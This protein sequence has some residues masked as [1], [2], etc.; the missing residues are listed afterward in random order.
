MSPDPILEVVIFEIK[1]GESAG[2]EAAIAQAFAFLQQTEGYLNHQ[3][4]R[5]L[6]RDHQ[7]LLTISWTT[8]DAHM[9]NFR[10]SDRFPRWRELIEPYFANPP[11]ML[12][13]QPI[14]ES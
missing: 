12:H 5:C 13:Y 3:L 2:F 6:E 10:Q 1:L 9:I 11:Q 14:F 4:R 8:V 7:Y